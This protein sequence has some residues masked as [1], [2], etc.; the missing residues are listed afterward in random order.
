MRRDKKQNPEQLKMINGR[1]KNTQINAKEIQKDTIK[2]R[3]HMGL[4][5]NYR[6]QEAQPLCPLHYVKWRMTQNRAC[7][8]MWK[9]NDVVEVVQM[10]RENK[11]K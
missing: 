7:A 2:I 9:K 8:S 6:K 5:K 4:K 1:R 3:L 10:F 11:R